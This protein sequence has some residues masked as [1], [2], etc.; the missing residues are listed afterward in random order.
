MNKQRNPIAESAC[1]RK[2]GTMHHKCEERGGARNYLREMIEE[3]LLEKE[4]MLQLMEEST[5][6]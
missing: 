1:F 2:A 3:F 4:E 6:E 5:K